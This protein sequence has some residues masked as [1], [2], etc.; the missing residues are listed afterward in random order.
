LA[1]G[2]HHELLHLTAKAITLNTRGTGVDDIPN[3]W[4]GERGFSHIG[5]QH[6][7][8]A[9]VI[10]KNTFLIGLRKPRKQWQNFRAT[11]HRAVGDMLAQMIGSFPDFTLSRQENQNVTRRM[12]RP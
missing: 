3:A 2:L 8:P 4:Y 11:G 1:N 5:G 12:T 9:A 10:V 6:N 7:S